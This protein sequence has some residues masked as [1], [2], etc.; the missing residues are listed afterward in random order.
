MM[1]I[2][3]R[4]LSGG[5]VLGERAVRLALAQRARTRDEAFCLAVAAGAAGWEAGDPA[6]ER[7]WY[8][9]E[10]AGNA[11]KAVEGFLGEAGV[12]VWLPRKKGGRAWHGSR[13]TPTR[14]AVLVPAF[15]GYIFVR[16]ANDPRAWHGLLA[17]KNVVG[18][19]GTAE[20][21]SP[22]ADSKIN[23]LR[24]MVDDGRLDQTVEARRL[25]KGDRVA[26]REGPFAWF[27][28]AV[29]GYAGTAHVRVLLALFGRETVVVLKLDEVA[30]A[31]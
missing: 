11:E 5:E 6:P 1:A 28:G 16:V 17:V 3:P 20:R 24:R 21:P 7:R 14:L 8:V 25:K 2:D 23:E 10:V 30:R 26:V 4:R 9:L 29:E 18:V 13:P 15:P 12:E 27:E 31:D 19:L 22:I